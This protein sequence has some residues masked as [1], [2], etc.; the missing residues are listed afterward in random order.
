MSVTC[1]NELISS[2]L[3]CN[4][5]A[6]KSVLNHCECDSGYYM[7][8]YANPCTVTPCS[9]CSLCNAVCKSCTAGDT[10]SCF[11]CYDG[12]FISGTQCL[13]CYSACL[14]CETSSTNCKSCGSGKFF[15]STQAT[16][17]LT[18]PYRYYG[19]SS[20]DTCIICSTLCQTCNG[21]TPSNCLTCKT[22]SYVSAGICLPCDSK[23]ET[24]S[25]TSTTCSSCLEGTTLYNNECIA[26]CP[27][28][29][30]TRSLDRTCQKCDASCVACTGQ[31]ALSCTECGEGQYL[32][33]GSCLVCEIICKT[34][35]TSSTKCT[36]CRTGFY[37]KNNE[38]K[39][40]CP[41]GYYPKN[42]DNTCQL[43]EGSC[44]K[45]SAGTSSDC[46]ECPDGTYLFSGKCL[47]C[48]I[49]KTCKDSASNCLSCNNPNF[50]T[51]YQ[52]L[53]NCPDGTWQKSIDNACKTCESSCKTCTAGTSSDC[54]S[55][56]DG[57]FFI[58]QQRMQSLQLELQDLHHF[59]YQLFKL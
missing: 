40:T 12:K 55:C 17:E 59:F 52:C 43:C 22:G 14:T 9:T 7:L 44:T 1:T 18:C 16:Y 36:S 23:C 19:G 15:I 4:A 35:L 45:C 58:G 48:S 26:G 51:N 50:L 8:A 5:H 39:A 28:G 13:A 41:N 31:D 21:A 46:T 27:K 20:T 47:S 57:F 24:C 30:Y 38:C 10:N 53:S 25:T 54:D 11:S 34:C 29:Y 6:I 56:F 3:T 32:S 42:S 49:C 37:C 33:S 2:C